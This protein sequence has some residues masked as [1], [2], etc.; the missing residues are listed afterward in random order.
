MFPHE[1]YDAA[2]PIGTAIVSVI[3]LMIRSAILQSTK[4]LGEKIGKIGTNLDVH[5]AEDAIIHPALERRLAKIENG[6][7]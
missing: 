4:E 7:V 5:I 2:F 1:F 6:K 3:G